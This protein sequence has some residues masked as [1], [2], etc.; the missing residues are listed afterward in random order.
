[1]NSLNIVVAE[2][3]P[4]DAEAVVE[5]IKALRPSWRV[6]AMARSDAETIDLVERYQPDVV[7]LDIGLSGPRTGIEIATEVAHQCPVIFVTG[8]M[9]HAV[10]AFDLGAVDY[11]VKPLTLA[12][13]DKAILR[14]EQMLRNSVLANGSAHG[15]GR[16]AA[17]EN[18]RYMQ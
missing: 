4:T 7:L 1:M 8:E 15:A 9:G 3:S 11:I 10:D 12:R 6:V 18:A 5:M 17:I 2:D 13:L 16:S 14:M